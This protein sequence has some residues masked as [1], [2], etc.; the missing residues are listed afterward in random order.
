M[1]R[2]RF[3]SPADPDTVTDLKRPM[4]ATEL[5]VADLPERQP[6]L[7]PNGLPDLGR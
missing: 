4:P 6:I 2:Q 5:M 3:P 1:P 7:D